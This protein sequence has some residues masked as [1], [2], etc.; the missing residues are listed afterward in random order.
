MPALALTYP[1]SEQRL[2][3]GLRVIVAPDPGS[4]GMAVNLWYQ[5]GSADEPIGRTGFAHLFEHLMFQGSA[6][7]ASGEHFAL[8]ESVGAI[9]NATT[10]FERTNYYETIPPGALELALWL[11]ADRM[12]SLSVTQANLDAQREVVKE[13]KRQTYDNQPYGDLLELLLGQHFASG[14]SYRH[15]T[16]GSMADLDAAALADVAQFFATWY[17]PNNAVLT[18]AGP[19]GPEEG[20]RLA[21]RYFGDIPPHPLPERRRCADWLPANRLEATGEVPHDVLYLS[22]QGPSI[23]DADAEA[24]DALLALLSDGLASRLHRRIIKQGDLADSVGS[25]SLTFSDTGSIL[26]ISAR[27]DADQS[28]EA[29]E[30]AILSEIAGLFQRPPDE[31]ELDRTRAQLERHYLSFLAEIDSRADLIS[32]TATQLGDPKWLLGYLDRLA[33]L[34]PERILTVAEKWLSPGRASVM[35]YRRAQS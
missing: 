30:E 24:A 32:A 3:N 27:V 10:S 20:F 11:E 9:A 28:L 26:T 33:Q 21:E 25:S 12:R 6:N 18:L 4:P 2:D 15:P 31:P 16:I 35:Y 5:V 23:P 1:M 13:E 7:V 19:L 17:R 34:T 29:V 22:W 8:L 14:S